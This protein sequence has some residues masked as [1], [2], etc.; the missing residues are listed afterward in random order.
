MWYYV[1]K[2]AVSAILIVLVSEIAKRSSFLGAVLASL[3]IVSLLAF[4]WL[5]Y[6][7]GD[8]QKISRLSLDIF[9]LVI[10]SLVLFL[11]FPWLLR[12]GIQFWPSLVG[13]CTATALCY[14]LLMVALRRFT[15]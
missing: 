3:P 7:T 13:A 15:A 2:V 8:T 14:G 4:V 10:P 1:I 5:Y 12:R 6:E 9:W 11:V